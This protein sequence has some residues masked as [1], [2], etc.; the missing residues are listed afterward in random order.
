MKLDIKKTLT[1]I[2]NIG[3]IAGIIFLAVEL[4]QNNE[5]LTAESEINLM[6]NRKYISEVIL[7]DE[8]LV[9]VFVKIDNGEPLAP[10]DQYRLDAMFNIYMVSFQWDFAQ[11]QEG[12]ISREQLPVESWINLINGEGMIKVP[13]DWKG[14]WEDKKRSLAP[15]FVSFMEESVFVQ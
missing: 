2:T 15:D 13:L 5:F 4:Q 3:V 12:R 14:L 10:A 1:I 6:Q 9:K 8:E 7:Q 11:F